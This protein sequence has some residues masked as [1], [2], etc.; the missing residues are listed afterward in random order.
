MLKFANINSVAFLLCDIQEK[1]RPAIYD[2]NSVVRVADRM[3]KAASILK[4]PLIVTEQYPKGL[5]STVKEIDIKS[6]KLFS[7]TKFSML[8]DDVKKEIANIN[9]ICLFGIEGKNVFLLADGISSRYKEEKYLALSV[10]ER[11]KATLAITTCRGPSNFKRMPFI[12]IVKGF[13]PSK[14]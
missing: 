13:G 4:R 10:T 11:L 5:G 2:F 9:D 6:A 1:F 14:L 7:K 3:V 12:P 8:T